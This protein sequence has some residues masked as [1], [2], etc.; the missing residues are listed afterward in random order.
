MREG[1]RPLIY[2]KSPLAAALI[3]WPKHITFDVLGKEAISGRNILVFWSKFVHV[4]TAIGVES[5]DVI[6]CQSQEQ[7]IGRDHRISGI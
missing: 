2:F 4:A 7:Q 3:E 1:E 6:I 5:V